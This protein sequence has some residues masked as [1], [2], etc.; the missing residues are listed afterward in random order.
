WE[1]PARECAAAIY[2]PAL[3]RREIE[4]T[5]MPQ[6]VGCV[7]TRDRFDV[8]RAW[9]TARLC[10]SL[11]WALAAA[12]FVIPLWSALF[13]GPAAAIAAAIVLVITLSTPRSGLLV[14]AGLLPL[15]APIG[16]LLGLPFDSRVAGELLLIPFLTAACARSVYRSGPG[17]DRL[18]VAV[19]A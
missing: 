14:L 17:S 18:A 16:Q 10:R 11:A 9:P 7:G 4:R 5:A 1:V 8:A 13:L 19:A 3:T 6:A 12:L 2:T 15:A